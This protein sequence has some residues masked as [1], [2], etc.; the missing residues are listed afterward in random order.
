MGRLIQFIRRNKYFLLAHH[1]KCEEY[2]EDTLHIKGKDFCIGC[3]ITIP[4]FILALG[5]TLITKWY[6]QISIQGLM[7]LGG[8][9]CFGYLLGKFG[10]HRLKSLNIFSKIL[11]GVGGSILISILWKIPIT[12]LSRILMTFVILQFA[13]MGHGFVR[14][15]SIYRTCQ[16]CEHHF[17]WRKCPGMHDIIENL[18]KGF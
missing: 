12:P 7:I 15:I 9:L 8:G 14:T 13:F 6:E 11:V 3:F 10:F 18:D 16:K 2:Y 4:T 1:P 17:E 5:I